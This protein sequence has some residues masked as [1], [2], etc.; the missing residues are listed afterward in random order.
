MKEIKNSDDAKA[1]ELKKQVLQREF[2]LRNVEIPYL[3]KEA[4]EYYRNYKQDI[5]NAI[6]NFDRKKDKIGTKYAQ[7]VVLYN[8]LKEGSYEEN[9]PNS[10][11][12]KLKVERNPKNNTTRVE[13][14]SQDN[15]SSVAV[16]YNSLGKPLLIEQYYDGKLRL[17]GSFRHTDN[18]EGYLSKIFIYTKGSKKASLISYDKNGNPEFYLA[19]NNDGKLIKSFEIDNKTLDVKTIILP[20]NSGKSWLKWYEYDAN[21]NL[22]TVLAKPSNGLPQRRYNF[23]NGV[24]KSLDLFNDM[25]KTPILHVPFEEESN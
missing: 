21:G 12:I 11:L 17:K 19:R 6:E 7:A 20:D 9:W 3:E 13:T 10:N 22:K 25:D 18:D 15:K 5:L 24:V 4:S 23:D 14:F 16:Y 8:G 2:Y 1:I